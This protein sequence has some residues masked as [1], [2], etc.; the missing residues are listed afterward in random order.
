MMVLQNDDRVNT[1]TLMI[2][3]N[4]VKWE[5]LL[6]CL[7][8]DLKEKNRPKIVVLC[9]IPRNPD[10]GSPVAGYMNGKVTKWNVMARNLTAENPS[11]LRLMDVESAL[12]MVD[13]GALTKNGIQLKTQPGIQLMNDAFQTRIEEM[14]TELQTMVNPVARG[15]PAGRVKYHVPRPLANRLGPLATEAN[16]VQPTNSSEVRERLGTAPAPRSRSLENRH[17]ARE[18]GRMWLTRQLRA[19]Q[20][21][22][23][24]RHRLK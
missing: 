21:D 7:L 19:L 20:P 3:K 4:E 14:E 15:S 17:G 9:T 6:I 13:H 1:L 24:G 2:G 22:L 16:V 5:S 23:Q 8:N 18:C 12:R 10:S 11:D